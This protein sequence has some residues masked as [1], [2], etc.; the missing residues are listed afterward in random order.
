MKSLFPVA[1][2]A[3]ATAC[4]GAPPPAPES[5]PPTPPATSAPPDEPPV[6]ANPEDIIPEPS[7]ECRK[8]AAPVAAEECPAEMATAIAERLSSPT[9]LL[10]WERCSGVEPGLMRALVAELSPI[11]C[12]D[13]LVEPSAGAPA[14]SGE[15]REVLNGLGVAARLARLA[16]EPPR[17]EPPYDKARFLDF[18]SSRL[19]PWMIAQAK[20]IDSLSKQGA[21]LHGYAMGV[22]AIQAG[23]ADLRMVE[24]MRQTSLPEEMAGDAEVEEVYFAALDQALEPRKTR[25]RDAALVGLRR[26]HEVGAIEDDRLSSA[27]RLLSL[28]Y[29]GR[30]IDRLEQLMLPARQDADK[31]AAF[32]A[33]P[34]YYA[35]KLIP[36]EKLRESLD[37]VSQRGL[38]PVLQQSIEAPGAKLL[39]PEKTYAYA[40]GLAHLSQRYFTRADFERAGKVAQ[41]IAKDKTYGTKA[42][43][44]SALGEAMVGAPDD[45]AKMMLGGFGDWKPNVKALDALGKGTGE[46]AGMAAFDA[47][48]LLELAAPQ[49]ADAAFWQDLAKR[50]TAAEK[51]LKGEAATRAKER[52]DAAKQTADSIGKQPA[53]H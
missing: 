8:L 14:P 19:A 48:F 41:G 53:A 21:G 15:V 39:P 33:M 5:P 6:L 28:L 25:G 20:A 10:A 22:V 51:R 32:S 3:L 4:G 1:V 34:T 13:V 2:L 44:L 23:L 40:L 42:K 43:L 36:A 26:F 29:N 35:G 9:R 7:A 49:T 24:L 16:G 18:L 31:V 12:A 45:A 37:S 27:H 38:P 50:Y 52:A 30:R 46:V 47:A 17:L 11:E